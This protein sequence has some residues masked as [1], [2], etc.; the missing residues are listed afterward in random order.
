MDPGVWGADWEMAALVQAEGSGLCLHLRLFVPKM[1]SQPL[2]CHPS[3]HRGM[4]SL[5]PQTRP[6]PR[7]ANFSLSAPGS[8]GRLSGNPG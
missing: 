4:W 7:V 5:V 8:Q 1:C 2:P 6:G 3:D